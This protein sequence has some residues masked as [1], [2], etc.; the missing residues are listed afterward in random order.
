MLQNKKKFGKI[1]IQWFF[2][3]CGAILGTPRYLVQ[4]NLV[5]KYLEKILWCFLFHIQ[6]KIEWCFSSKILKKWVKVRSFDSWLLIG[7]LDLSLTNQEPGV[8]GPHFDSFFQY[9]WRKT[10]FY[11]LLNMKQKTSKNLFQIFF[12]QISSY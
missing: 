12:H 11:F 7:C 5:K 3:L 9:L 8:K 1:F 10:P 6:K 4:R 2:C